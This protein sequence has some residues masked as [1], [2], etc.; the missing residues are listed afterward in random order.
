V[1][2]HDNEGHSSGA[3]APE[4]GGDQPEGTNS[5]PAAA[6]PT[7]RLD[8]VAHIRAQIQANPEGYAN[9]SKLMAC[10]DRLIRDLAP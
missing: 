2:D 9:D 3:R 1:T 7:P 6:H 5:H 8:L 10:L 4:G